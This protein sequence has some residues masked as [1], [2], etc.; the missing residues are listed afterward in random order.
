MFE[1]QSAQFSLMVFCLHNCC[2]YRYHN[3][4]V[5]ETCFSD[6][7]NKYAHSVTPCST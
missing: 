3:R 4:T 6:I 7:C 1:T 2:S 5:A